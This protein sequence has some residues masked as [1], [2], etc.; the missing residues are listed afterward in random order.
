MKCKRG[1]SYRQ[2]YLI[3][4]SRVIRISYTNNAVPATFKGVSQASEMT[5]KD[6]SSYDLTRS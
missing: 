3:S 5:R 1:D 4:S 6:V 2:T